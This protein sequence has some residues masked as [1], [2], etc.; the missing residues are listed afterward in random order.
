MQNLIQHD[1]SL[2][3]GNSGGP[4][5]NMQGEVVGINTLKITS[6]E[7]IGFAI[8]AK[9]FESLIGSFVKNINYKIPY[10]GLYGYD[11]EIASYYHKTNKDKGFYVIEIDKFSP[12]YKCG[13]R[14]SSIITE[15]NGRKIKVKETC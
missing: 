13:V 12:L 9:S 7:G 15:L 11:S 6:G 3:P 14:P 8:P 10:L 5:L 1:A 4:L 2:N